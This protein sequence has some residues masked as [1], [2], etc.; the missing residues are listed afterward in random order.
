[1]ADVDVDLGLPG[2][3]LAGKP[4]QVFTVDTRALSPD[5]ALRACALTQTPAGQKPGTY[6]LKEMGAM[7]VVTC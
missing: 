2:L 3:L 5:H 4:S 1:M 7:S 6:G